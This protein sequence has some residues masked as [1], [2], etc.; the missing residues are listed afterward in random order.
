MFPHGDRTK[1]VATMFIVAKTMAM[2]IMM[3]DLHLSSYIEQLKN[4]DDGQRRFKRGEAFVSVR[5]VCKERLTMYGV[6]I[7][8]RRVSRIGGNGGRCITCDPKENK[9]R[10]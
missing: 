1:I 8:R 6:E 9:R 3:I 4:Q 2:V 7:L 10:M 5:M